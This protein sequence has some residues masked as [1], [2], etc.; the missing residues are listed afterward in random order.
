M[1]W[2]F[3]MNRIIVFRDEVRLRKHRNI[4]FND[5]RLPRAKDLA[6]QLISDL[7]KEYRIK[8]SFPGTKPDMIV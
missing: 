2:S 1:S 4:R 5:A 7:E 6:L 8:L 3:Q